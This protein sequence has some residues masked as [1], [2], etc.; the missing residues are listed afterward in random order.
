MSVIKDTIEGLAKGWSWPT[1]KEHPLRKLL[2]TKAF[3]RCGGIKVSVDNG[4]FSRDFTFR[5][6]KKNGDLRIWTRS[7]SGL[8]QWRTDPVKGDR[9]VYKAFGKN[10]PTE[11]LSLEEIFLDPHDVD[12]GEVAMFEVLYADLV[13]MLPSFSAAIKEADKFLEVYIGNSRNT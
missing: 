1:V 3:E 5:H 12:E 2:L 7:M 10:D 8:L 6:E 13:P 9:L 11:R 4:G